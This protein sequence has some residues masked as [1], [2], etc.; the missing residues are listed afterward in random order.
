MGKR[1]DVAIEKTHLILALVDPAEIA[2][3]VHQPQEQEPGFWADAG[4]IDEDLEEV[5]FRQIPG[6]I[7]QRN[8]HLPPLAPPLG[9]GRFHQRDAN[10]VALRHEQLMQPRRRQL[11][12]RPGP[13]RGLGQQR[14]NPGPDLGPHRTRPG[15]RLLAPRHRLREILPHGPAGNPQLAGH[16]PTRAALHEYFVPDDVDLIHPEHPPADSGCTTSGKPVAASQVDHFP[17]G[18]STN[19]APR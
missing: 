7:R 6:A 11:L 17:S 5:D 4:D 1:A 19:G 15:L 12:L 3:R 9:H 2:A 10:G 14:L 13:P 18:A 16:L 8:E